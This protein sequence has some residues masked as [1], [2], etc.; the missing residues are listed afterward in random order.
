MSIL[1]TFIPFLFIIYY[2]IVVSK[3]RYISSDLRSGKR[4]YICKEQLEIDT[5]SA[6]NILVSDKSNYQICKSCEREEKLDGLI[7]GDK[8][9]KI[10]KL[11]F[12]LVSRRFDKTIA[13]LII[14][15]VVLLGIDLTLKLAFDIKWFS[16]IY[17][18]FLVSYWMLII[19]RH[20][21]ISVK[22]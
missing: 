16:Y 18:I 13:F 6:L 11:K 22:K 10:H 1:L 3:T 21:L 2:S 8:L 20:K 14:L 15:L 5:I 4:C 17:N 19:Y 7:N 9:S 12:Y